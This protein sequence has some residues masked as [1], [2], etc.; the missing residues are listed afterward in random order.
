MPGLTVA[1]CV[2]S[3]CLLFAERDRLY[4]ELLWDITR[5]SRD[6]RDQRFMNNA[7]D[8]LG[9]RWLQNGSIYNRSMDG[10]CP[11][12][13]RVTVLSLKDICR[14]NCKQYKIG[15][16]K[17][18]LPY[19]WHYLKIQTAKAKREGSIQMKTWWL[20]DGWNSTTQE[21]EGK[22]KFLKGTEWLASLHKT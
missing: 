11:N 9:I 4:I 14:H 15:G 20:R 18:H 7:L 19:I 5:K 16:D 3:F 12:G 6:K 17:E 22:R 1:T 10:E 13:L 8:Q 21:T 2:H